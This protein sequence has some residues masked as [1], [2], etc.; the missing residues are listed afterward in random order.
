MQ[1]IPDEDL[2]TLKRMEALVDKAPILTR[3][4][5]E[6]GYGII[7]EDFWKLRNSL[8]TLFDIKYYD[9]D[10]GYEDDILACWSAIR[11]RWK[12][13]EDDTSN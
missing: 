7:W 9:P 13:L 1:L 2:E 6:D 10:M 8:G 11:K 3:K 12:A 4:L 5:N